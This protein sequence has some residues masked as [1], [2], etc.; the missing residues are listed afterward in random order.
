MV[1]TLTPAGCGSRQRVPRRSRPLHGGVGAGR[2]GARRGAR[3]GGLAA[4]PRRGRSAS[5]AR[6]RRSWRPRV[7]PAS[8]A[9]RC[10]SCAVR[11][12]SAG[13]ASGRWPAGR[14]GYGVGPRRGRAHPPGGLDL[15]GHGRRRPRA[16]RPA[17]LR[18]SASSPSALGRALMVVL[19]TPGGRRGRRRR[20]PHGRAPPLAAAGE[21]R[22]A[23]GRGRPDRRLAGAR[24]AATQGEYDPA[25]SGR[26][27][28][29]AV[30]DAAGAAVVVRPPS[31]PA[32]RYDG[33]P[34]AGPRR[35]PAGLR[36][37]R[38][39]ARRA[40]AHRRGGRP[41]L[42]RHAHQA[43]PRLP[44]GRLRARGRRRRPAPGAA[45]RWPPARIRVGR[46]G[47][48][49]VRPRPPRPA[50]RADR[51]ARRRGPPL[52]DPPR[53]GRRLAPGAA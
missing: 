32:V 19:P 41:A 35:R 53:P 9:S 10:P 22:R 46:P 36:R 24:A 26:V 13:A 18:R 16:R 38:R 8:C 52:A 25:A 44:A 21:R 3:P 40:L 28:A 23:A 37:R 5:V 39:R 12:P 45:Q 14:F 1:E 51:L 47:G 31:L 33:R 50:R 27:L 42:E 2:G 43:R 30:S 48:P 49:R 7:R 6:A 34:L 15:L 11:C 17:R 29:V 4:R 20:R